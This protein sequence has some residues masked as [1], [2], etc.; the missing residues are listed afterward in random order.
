MASWYGI[1]TF[2]WKG[3]SIVITMSDLE[4]CTMW[5]R[6]NLANWE[7]EKIMAKTLGKKRFLKSLLLFLCTLPEKEKNSRADLAWTLETASYVNQREEALRL[8]L[9]RM[10]FNLA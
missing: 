7:N 8:S 10:Y 5:S 6:A 4:P 3:V 9:L 1:P 2:F